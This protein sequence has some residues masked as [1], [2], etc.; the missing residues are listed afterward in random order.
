[1]QKLLLPEGWD[2]PKG[3]SNGVAVTGSRW[4][5]LG[6]QIGWN[7]QQQFESDDFLDQL[8][9]T[10]RN[11]VDVLAAGGA[12]PRHLVRLTWYITDRA[13]YVEDL[14]EVG[15]IYRSV[16]GKHFPPMTVVEVKA[17]VE[18]RAKVEIEATA[19]LD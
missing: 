4:L 18:D 2:P 14:R 13:A 3:Y 11:V 12:E 10:L 15:R 7:A 16:L 17:L 5:F 8:E 19:V 9:Q 6:G 1:M